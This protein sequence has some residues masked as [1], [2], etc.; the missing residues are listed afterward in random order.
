MTPRQPAQ[1]QGAKPGRAHGSKDVE[2]EERRNPLPA[3]ALRCRNCETEHALEAIGICS[4][5]WGPLDPIYDR[6]ELARLATREAIEAGPPSLWRYAP[7]LP[8]AAGRAAARARPDAARRGP[9]LAEELG[10]GE[11]YLK[12]D[13]AN[14]THS[15]KDRVVAVAAA[16]AQELGLTTLACSSTGNLAERRRRPRGRRGA[17]GRRLLPGRPRAGE[18]RRDRRLRRDDLRGPRHLR[19]LQ[20]ADD[21]ALVRAALGA[22]STWA[23]APTTP[24]ARRRSRTRSPSSSAGSCPTWSSRRSRPARSSRRSDA[25]LRPDFP[26]LGLVDGELPR[27]F[28]AQAAGC[29]PVA[30]AFADG[31]S[32]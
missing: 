22:S 28:G 14:P 29:A 27:Q 4:Q 26:A 18:A 21:R 5:C 11:L 24:R 25:G 20:P 3:T 2:R 32:A 13:T 7:L 8:V 30:T 1:R 16:K 15:F 31:S 19:R 10:V 23:C 12:L 17:R 6:A 9:R